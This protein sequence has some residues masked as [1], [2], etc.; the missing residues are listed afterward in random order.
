MRVEQIAIFLENKSGRLAEITALLAENDINIRALSV[1][2]TADFGILRLIVDKVDHAKTV[3]KENGFT[4]GGTTVIAVKVQD[5]T[6]G[7]ASVLK[8]IDGQD[9]NVEYMYSIVNKLYDGAILIMRFDEVD[10]AI[11]VLQDNGVTILTGE[12]IYS[13]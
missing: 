4:V 3:L 8:I 10:K 5:K 6:G 1:A 12:Q 9:L 11:Q 2:D 13:L 7:L